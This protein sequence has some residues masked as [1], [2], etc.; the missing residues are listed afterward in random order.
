MKKRRTLI[1]A[2]LL[3]AALCLGIGY[4]EITDTLTV[5]GDANAK[6]HQENL[7]VEFTEI[8]NKIK[9]SGEIQTD[10][11][12]A[13]FNTTQLVVKDDTASAE[14]TVMNKSAEYS[15]TIAAP[16]I[17]F[18]SG[19]EYFDVTTD[20]G[21]GTTRELAPNQSTTFTV[22]VK[23]KHA[24]TDERACKFTIINNVTAVEPAAAT[25]E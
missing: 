13:T 18:T 21:E 11:T 6:P 4:A 25:L 2:L 8:N 14:Y 16:S 24:V 9:C 22:T 5:N 12:V 19:S 20:F 15:A 7:V 23:L 10:H 17:S 1:I 3:V